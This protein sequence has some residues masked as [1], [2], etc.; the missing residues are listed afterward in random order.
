M[1]KI[2]VAI[3]GYGG[4]ARLHYAAYRHLLDSGYPVEVVAVCE[5]N[6]ESVFKSVSINLG[7]E[8]VALDENTHIY[9]DVDD[10]LLNEEFDMADICLPTFLHK[11]FSVKLLAAGKHVLIEKPM[12][13]S[14]A[15]C[16]E[17]IETSRKAEK[18]LMV[19]QC[20]R[21][22][23]VYRFLKTCIEDKRL[24]AL[25]YLELY[26]LCD[27]PS[28]G[29]DFKSAER[30]G[31]CI[32]DTHIHD[33][34]I[35][36]YLLGEPNEISC[37]EYRDIPRCQL[38]DSRLYYDNAVVRA[39]VAWD[40]TR[41]IPFSAGYHARFDQGDVICEGDNVEVFEKG[42]ERYQI[43]LEG[44]NMIEEE[45]RAFCDAIFVGRYCP[46]NTPESSMNSV[47]LIEALKNSADKRGE[48]IKFSL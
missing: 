3:I 37:L 2:K 21:F 47:L 17:M 12:A 32:L 38:A 11:E 13:L 23:Q 44:K 34:D 22:N 39:E 36:R 1:K 28:W 29:A 46:D 41:K 7:G 19:G 24:G 10:L 18:L 20:L 25:R 35:A 45:I 6:K 40:E 16:L 8:A 5:K 15:D 42:K 4:I 48:K 43:R 14:S 30:T 33:I 26:R 31:G 27:Y 9:S